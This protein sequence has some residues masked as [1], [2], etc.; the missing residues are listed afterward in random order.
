MRDR[1]W[2][3]ISQLTGK[4]FELEKFHELKLR[5]VLEA[6]LLEYRE[7]IEEITDGA[8]KQLAIERKIMEIQALW[9]VQSFEF[10][11]WKDRGDV[12]LAGASVADIT[13]QLEDSQASLIQM[14]TQRHVTPFRDQAN[15][16]LKKL[17]DVNDTLESWVKVQMLWM[18]LEAVFTGGD[19][20]R[21]M[22]QDTRV[23]MKVDKEWTTRLMNKAKD[24]KLVV[25]ACQ[26]EYI[27]N[28][29]PTMFVDLEKCQ[30]AL[31][32]YLEQ[33]RQKFPRFYFVSNPALLLILSQGS[34]KDAVQQCFSKVFD[35]IDRVEFQVALNICSAVLPAALQS[36]FARFWGSRWR[37]FLFSQARHATVS[38]LR[39]CRWVRLWD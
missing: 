29:L 34:D 38:A 35:A 32:G 14:L 19:I 12:I 36:A 7:D 26:N 27:K 17:S 2:K 1:H 18:S 10:A 5:S 31:D 30:K 9:D 25:E 37:F 28:M 16:W 15:I 22:P 6:N 13:E 21:Q 11:A 3:K 39:S 20:A 23:F 24:V 4:E 8:E 33:K